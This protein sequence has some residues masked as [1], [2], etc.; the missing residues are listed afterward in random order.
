MSSSGIF[1]VNPFK[2]VVNPNTAKYYY[3]EYTKIST[4]S[5]RNEFI[6]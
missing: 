6:Q 1:I 5:L 2:D 3:F 4:F